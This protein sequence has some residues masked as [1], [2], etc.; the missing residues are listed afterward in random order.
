MGSGCDG[1][2]SKNVEVIEATPDHVLHCWKSL[3]HHLK[4]ATSIAS[5][6]EPKFDNI[7]W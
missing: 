3:T 2:D 1:S 5:L 7:K 6:N 4:P